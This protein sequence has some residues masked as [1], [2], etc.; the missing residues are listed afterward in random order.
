MNGRKVYTLRR[1]VMQIVLTGAGIMGAGVIGVQAQLESDPRPPFG[2]SKTR[3]F[4]S[5]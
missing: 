5:K 2:P 4:P 1:G 3:P